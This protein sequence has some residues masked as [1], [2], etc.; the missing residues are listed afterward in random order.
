LGDR[1]GHAFDLW[2]VCSGRMPT[3]AQWASCPGCAPR[4]RYPSAS[5]RSARGTAWAI[6]Y[7]GSDRRCMRSILFSRSQATLTFRY[8]ATWILPSLW[9]SWKMRR[10]SSLRQSMS[11]KFEGA[12]GAVNVAARTLNSEGLAALQAKLAPH[13]QMMRRYTY[14]N[15]WHASEHESA[16]MWGL[17]QGDGRG[18]AVKSTFNR[19]INSLQS[20]RLIYAGMVRYIDYDHEAVPEGNAFAPYRTNEL[21]PRRLVCSACLGRW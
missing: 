21:D 15:C 18:V 19:L 8:G 10:C 7:S 6:S 5:R 13:T 3:A 4:P 12:M 2:L 16:A 17:Y 20:E 9:R 11:D 1:S 14:L